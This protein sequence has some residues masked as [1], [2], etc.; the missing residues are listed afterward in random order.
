MSEFRGGCCHETL[1]QSYGSGAGKLVRRLADDNIGVVEAR[2]AQEHERT[3][4][5]TRVCRS[6]A[7]SAPRISRYKSAFR[8]NGSRSR[9]LDW[10]GGFDMDAHRPVVMQ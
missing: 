3:D 7:C 8:T 10:S 9:K 5:P 2:S 4:G 6:V 1:P